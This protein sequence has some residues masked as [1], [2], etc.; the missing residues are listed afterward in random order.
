MYVFDN[1]GYVVLV[2]TGTRGD[3]GILGT[4][5]QPDERTNEKGTDNPYC[6]GLG[7]SH[8]ANAPENRHRVN[9]AQ[10]FAPGNQQC[11]H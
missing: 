6:I 10:G 5:Q 8:Q 1:K 7:G 9:V 2:F 3:M 11:L 4:N